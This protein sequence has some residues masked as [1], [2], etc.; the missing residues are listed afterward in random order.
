[1]RHRF[2]ILVAAACLTLVAGCGDSTAP[3]DP[4]T[5]TLAWNVA[6]RPAFFPPFDVSR[7][8]SEVRVLGTFE[9]LCVPT[10]G[11]ADV[12]MEGGTLV[13]ELTAEAG[14]GC[15]PALQTILYD[16]TIANGRSATRMR[17]V[18]RWPGTERSDETV[19]DGPFV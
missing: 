1:M 4:P 2:S 18:H 19:F 6:P 16:A 5:V 7:A 14:E 10:A 8:G 11:Q 12:R 13:L 3:E 9:A 17:I 15:S